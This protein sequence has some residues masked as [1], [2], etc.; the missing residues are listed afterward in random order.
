MLILFFVR[1]RKNRR[2]SGRRLTAGSGAAA[3]QTRE[4][5]PASSGPLMS[6]ASQVPLAAA[7]FIRRWRPESQQSAST[8]TAPSE[9]GFVRVSGRK[10]P[11]VLGGAGGDG[12][13]GGYD[14]EIPTDSYDATRALPGRT[15]RPITPAS[16]PTPTGSSS[17]PYA[18][19]GT[20]KD[21]EAGAVLRSS[22][23]RTPVV[24]RGSLSPFPTPP[25]TSTRRPPASDGVGRSHASHDG[26]RGSRFTEDVV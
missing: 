20:M 21:A 15:F 2:D 3:G 9:Q 23:A 24:S 8:E 6:R 14:K 4:L 18:F 19:D 11:S 22:P 7:A 25:A 26:S 13:G 10:I 16:R 5:D 1:H 12:Y 17:G